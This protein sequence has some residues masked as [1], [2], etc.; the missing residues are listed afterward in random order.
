MTGSASRRSLIARRADRPCSVKNSRGGRCEASSR[1]SPRARRL[2]ARG[3][4]FGSPA[5][6]PPRQTRIGNP[7]ATVG[8][9]EKNWSS[10]RR[11]YSRSPGANPAIDCCHVSF[12]AP[13]IAYAGCDRWPRYPP[14]TVRQSRRADRMGS[15][16]DTDRD[17][18]GAGNAPA[19]AWRVFRCIE[20]PPC[21]GCPSQ[22]CVRAAM[23]G[24]TAFG[25]VAPA[26]PSTSADVSVPSLSSNSRTHRS[27]RRSSWCSGAAA[28]IS[29]YERLCGR[30][31][32]NHVSSPAST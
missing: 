29:N 14:D 3:G 19:R 22:A 10:S 1:I 7:S 2:P 28:P 18:A 21:N 23:L 25:C 6:W 32:R 8:R 13:S 5:C 9:V 26:P 30:L 31:I 17:P 27:R 24:S 16:P 11:M 15:V 12:M 20:S 4:I